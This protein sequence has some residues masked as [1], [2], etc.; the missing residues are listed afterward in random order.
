MTTVYWLI[1]TA[2]IGGLVV[3][4]VFTIVLLVFARVLRWVYDGG[5]VPDAVAEE[6]RDA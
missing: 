4:A 2:G 1:N 6:R 3:L 5:R